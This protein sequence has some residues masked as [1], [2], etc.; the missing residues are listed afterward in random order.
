MELNTQQ[1]LLLITI[2]FLAGG[3]FPY[4]K[5]EETHTV[6]TIVRSIFLFICV[7]GVCLSFGE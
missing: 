7:I 4:P 6:M 5:D 1:I 3:W 2:A